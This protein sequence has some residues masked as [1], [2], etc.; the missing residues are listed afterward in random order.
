MPLPDLPRSAAVTA[1]AALLAGAL[2][3]GAP[4]PTPEHEARRDSLTA[5]APLERLPDDAA[6]ALVRRAIEAHG[7]WDAWAALPAVDYRKTTISLAEDGTASDSTVERH[8]Y[9][10]HPGPRMRIDWTDPDGRH[11]T[12]MNDGDE[13]WRFVDGRESRS[14]LNPHQA[15]NSTFGSHYV[16]GQPFKLTDAGTNLTYLG[17]DSLEDGTAVEGVR[18]TYDPGVGSSGGMHTWV[19]YVDASSGRLAGYRFGEGEAVDPAT[20]TTYGDYADVEGVRIYRRRTTYA[21]GDDGSLRP[22]RVYRHEAHDP[23][24]LPDSIFVHPDRR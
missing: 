11:V 6:G 3:C 10:L 23:S 21:V 8:R 14:P 20:F 17:P 13:A 9:A 15:W 7:G 2:S 22:V 5:L 18:V 16:F 12:L 19:Y 4:E 24:P 1:T